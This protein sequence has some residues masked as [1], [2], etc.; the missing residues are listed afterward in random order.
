ME[1]NEI[2]D[3]NPNPQSRT[4][5]LA[6]L[7][8]KGTGKT[9]ALAIIGNH[10]K[11]RVLYIDTIGALVKDRLI[12][13]AVYLRVSTL[14]RDKLIRALEGAFKSRTKDNKPVM[15]VVLDLGNL[16]PKE[17]VYCVDIVSSWVMMVGD[18][19]V[20]LDEVAFI[21]PQDSRVYSDEF[22]RL[23]LAGRNN[24]V[25]PVIFTTQ[26]SQTAHKNVLALADKY[27]IFRLIHNLDRNK[28]KDLIGLKPDEWEQLEPQL[29]SLQTKEAFLFYTEGG[30]RI[31]K[32]IVMPDYRVK[33]ERY[34][35]ETGTDS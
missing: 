19:A 34:G 13:D 31:L 3:E 16:I 27:I 7:G 2:V 33:G 5:T 35:A 23:V 18:M 26:R 14:D 25:V 1:L 9:R 6:I 24:N 20:L 32:R 12:P 4:T 10:L 11:C 29:M 30:N 17:K 15:R 8:Q 21:C 22:H 28:V